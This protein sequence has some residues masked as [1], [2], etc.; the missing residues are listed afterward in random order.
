[1]VQGSVVMVRKV[2]LAGLLTQALAAPVLAQAPGAPKLPGSPEQRQAEPGTVTPVTQPDGSL[3]TDTLLGDPGG[4]RSRLLSRGLALTL[5]ETSEVLGNPTGGLQQTVVYDGLTRV[6]VRLD[7]EKAFGLPGGTFN[8]TVF[9]IHGRGLSQNALGSNLHTVSNIEASNRGTL[10]GELWY[11]QS[12]FDGRLDVRVGQ[13]LADQE[14]LASDFAGLFINATFGF[15]TYTANTLPSG[16][17][18]YP[19]AALGVRVQVRPA[20]GWIVRGAAFNGDPVGPVREGQRSI[21]PSGTAFRLDDG[22]FAIAEVEYGLNGGDQ[23]TGLPGTYKL[24]GW[25][26]TEDFEDPRRGANGQLLSDPL[27]EGRPMARVSNWSIYAVADQLVYREPG[28]RDQGVGVFARIMGG[29]GD[30]NLLNFYVDAGVTYKGLLPGRV[31]DTLG[32][33][34]AF[35]RFSDQVSKADSDA[36]QAGSPR[37]IR[38]GETVLE[39]TYQAA[40][41]PWWQVQPVA[42]YVFRPSGAPDPVR[43]NRLLRDALVLGLRTNITF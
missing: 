16:G 4:V 9:Q 28:T 40:V 42:Q 7:T 8:A 10:L 39:L 33:A 38:R 6:G 36:V 22:V 34:V 19:L 25:Y 41:T 31:N 35:A 17:P 15:P 12:A 5:S 24:G 32:L 1:M 20:D 30:R 2:L 3:D 13:L 18:A 21:N 29:P 23:A 11:E 37:P 43:P 14:F 26:H 27:S